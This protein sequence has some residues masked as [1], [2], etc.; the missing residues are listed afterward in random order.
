MKNLIRSLA[1]LSLLATTAPGL[2]QP[3]GGRPPAPP[4]SLISYD[5]AATAMAAA[6]AH[7]RENGWPM[8]IRIVDQN[9]NVVMVHRM[10]DANPFTA[11][12]AERKTLT[13]IGSMMTSAEYGMK[14]EAGEIDEIENA[15]TFGGGVPIYLNGE[16][17][18]AIAASG[19]RPEEDEEV[20]R[21]GVEAI[22]GTISAD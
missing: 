20:S 8:T 6:E 22:G 3:P 18:G 5:Q 7:A 19:A 16:L 9:N 2:A 4:P 11:M 13:V 10:Q 21:A 14:V 17:I 1:V 15:V 12:I